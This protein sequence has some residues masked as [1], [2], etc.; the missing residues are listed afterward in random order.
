MNHFVKSLWL[1]ALVSPPCWKC[2]LKR[3]PFMCIAIVIPL[4]LL[5][6]IYDVIPL[7]AL[8][9]AGGMFLFLITPRN[10]F[11][12][13]ENGKT[14][15]FF[16]Y[17]TYNKWKVCVNEQNRSAILRVWIK[18]KGKL[19][20]AC[21]QLEIGGFNDSLI[22]LGFFL[23]K[24]HY[25]EWRLWGN[26]F[27]EQGEPLLLGRKMASYAF[28]STRKKSPIYFI[29]GQTIVTVPFDGVQKFD[30]LFSDYRQTIYQEIVDSQDC[31]T[32]AETAHAK[33]GSFLLVEYKKTLRLYKVINETNAP[34]VYLVY[35]PCFSFSDFKKGK[36]CIYIQHNDF[37]YVATTHA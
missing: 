19:R 12:L 26:G 13:E 14:L 7:L 36:Q 34:A 2:A 31:T 32:P 22:P 24:S 27:T 3:S 11:K 16:C 25:S 8:C 10:R 9:W 21:D 29:H 20:K 28:I 37:G 30:Q 5:C 17:D 15:Y 1:G 18:E 33:V 4:F 23:V 6:G 35:A